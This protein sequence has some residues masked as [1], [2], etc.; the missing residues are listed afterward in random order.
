MSQRFARPYAKATLAAAGSLETG[1]QLQADLERFTEAAREV[2]AI[3]RMAANPA[4][5]R[6]VKE[7]TLAEICRCLD[8]GPLTSSLIQ[9]LARN[10]RL[11][12]VDAVL[13]AVGE[14]LDRRLGVSTA[15]VITA[16]PLAD[17]Q[18]ARLRQVLGDMLEQQVRL[19][20]STRPELL[21]GFV[22]RIGSRRYD[23]S[24]N[25][26]LERMATT[27]AQG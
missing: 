15:E 17:S 3:Q 26:Q 23:A 6:E 19:T 16:Q 7:Q 1:Q 18:E 21:A 2:P 14:I 25:G 11:A 8:I 9:L 10:F 20:T 22:A 27:L 5:P 24:L 4:V 13:G 12:H